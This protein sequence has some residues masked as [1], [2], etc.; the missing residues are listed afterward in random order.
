[1]GIAIRC[2][3][4]Q[5]PCP[6]AR[7]F[8]LANTPTRLKAMGEELQQRLVNWAYAICDAAIRKHVNTTGAAPA[9]FPFKTAGV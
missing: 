3:A 9:G 4:E 2:A 7:A 5:H 6:N 8:E 1:M